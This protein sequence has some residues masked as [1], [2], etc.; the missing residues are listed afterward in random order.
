MMWSKEFIIEE[1]NQNEDCLTLN[2][3]TDKTST[4]SDRP[5]IVYIH[6]GG[7]T[8][9]GSS[10]LVYDGEGIAEKGAVYVSINYRV[11]VFGF[12]STEQL[13]AENE[14]GASGNYGLMDAVAALEWVQSNISQF[15][16]DPENVTIMGQSAGSRMVSALLI[17]PLAEGLFTKA[18]A[19]SAN[20]FSGT[21]GV[22]P[23]EDADVSGKKLLE[24]AGVNTI[25]ELRELSSQEVFDLAQKVS[26]GPFGGF[27]AAM[28]KRWIIF[29]RN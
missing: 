20:P 5:V 6:G 21:M 8:S 22:I 25:D 17:S 14:K 7:L 3:W 24:I 2:V 12:L 27:P 16:G 26:A 4:R 13:S 18:V 1:N 9:G 29:N 19:E 11:G 10:C 15:G 28:G 23:M